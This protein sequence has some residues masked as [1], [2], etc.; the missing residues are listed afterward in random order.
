M[1]RSAFSVVRDDDGGWNV[2]VNG[3]LLRFD[4]ME[5]TLRAVRLASRVEEL[6]GKQ[7]VIVVQQDDGSFLSHCST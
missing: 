3:A 1:I 2:V 4:T 7:V 5:Q 6:C